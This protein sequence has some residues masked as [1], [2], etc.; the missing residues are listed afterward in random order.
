ML[1]FI[2][3][4]ISSIIIGAVV[5]AVVILIIVK[6]VKKGNKSF[7]SCGDCSSCN[8]CG[9]CDSKIDGKNIV[10]KKINND[11]KHLKQ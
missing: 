4:N 8:A 10:I 6:L 2:T 11:S 5:L 3:E 1:E 7:C 9:V